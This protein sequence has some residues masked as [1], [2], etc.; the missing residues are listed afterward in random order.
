VIGDEESVSRAIN[1]G[2]NTSLFGFRS[3]DRAGQPDLVVA[4]PAGP[5][6]LTLGLGRED[7]SIFVLFATAVGAVAALW[8][9][10][11]AARQLAR[12]IGS[13]RTAALVG[14]WRA[15]H[16][17]RRTDGRVPSGV[18][19]V[20]T[21]GVRSQREPLGVEDAQRR[22]MAILRNVASGG[23]PSTPGRVLLAN[24]RADVLLDAAAGNAAR[25]CRPASFTEAVARVLA[26]HEEDGPRAADARRRAR[27]ARLPNAARRRRH[28]ARRC[29]QV[30]R[31]QRAAVRWRQVAHE[32][33]N[34]HAHPAGRPAP[35]GHAPTSAGTSIVCSSRT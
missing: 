30:A 31:A 32:I 24:P 7:L 34:A 26:G 11:I 10:G 27:A 5:E 19:R 28:H 33:K 21:N 3:I 9:S 16:P 12:P 20:S 8:L 17:R 25:R 14:G 13:L 6:E 23:L 18:R 2:S 1:V 15:T 22:I 4:A 35:A 29:P